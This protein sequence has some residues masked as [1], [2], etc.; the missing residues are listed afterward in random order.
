MKDR[1]IS[2]DNS[3]A[4]AADDDFKIIKCKIIL[5]N[6]FEDLQISSP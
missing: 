4:A 3:S 1:E 5:Q 2:C 6:I